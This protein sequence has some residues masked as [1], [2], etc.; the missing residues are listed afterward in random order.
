[1]YQLRKIA[2]QVLNQALSIGSV[3]EQ[4]IAKARD[5][6]RKSSGSEAE[7]SHHHRPRHQP[8]PLL[9]GVAGEGMA[10]VLRGF[11]G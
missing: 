6:D 1:M 5:G 4:V 8:K 11:G 7:R 2:L 10:M 9:Y 3:P